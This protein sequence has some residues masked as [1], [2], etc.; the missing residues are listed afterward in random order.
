MLLRIMSLIWSKYLIPRPLRSLLTMDLTSMAVWFLTLNSSSMRS[1]GNAFC[2]MCSHRKA[3][4]YASGLDSDLVWMTARMPLI[5]PNR[6]SHLFEFS[7][8]LKKAIVISIR[9][10]TRS[11]SFSAGSYPSNCVILVRAFSLRKC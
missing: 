3:S 11:V 8:C 4:T 10:V 5:A 2:R 9:V 7:I 1:A 6:S